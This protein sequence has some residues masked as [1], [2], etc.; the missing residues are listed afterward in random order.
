MSSLVSFSLAIMCLFTDHSFF[1]Q[2]PFNVPVPHCPPLLRHANVKKL[3]NKPITVLW[4]FQAKGRPC[5][6]KGGGGCVIG[7]KIAE[8]VGA[9]IVDNLKLDD[10][11]TAALVMAAAKGKAKKG[12]GKKKKKGKKKGGKQ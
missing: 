6:P 2:S 10:E 9:P 12:G 5:G 11:A 4:P 8:G 1:S 3:K 7:S